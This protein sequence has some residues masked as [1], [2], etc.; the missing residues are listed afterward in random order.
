MVDLSVWETKRGLDGVGLF[1]H[2]KCQP[3][4]KTGFAELGKKSAFAYV[5]RPTCFV[6]EKH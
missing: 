6:E 4:L 5:N 2:T 1:C 3:M